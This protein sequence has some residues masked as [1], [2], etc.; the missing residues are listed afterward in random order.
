MAHV[1]FLAEKK[2]NISKYIKK[3]PNKCKK[4]KTGMSVLRIPDAHISAL[5]VRVCVYEMRHRVGMS[6]N[7]DQDTYSQKHFIGGSTDA[8]SP[9]RLLWSITFEITT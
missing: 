5:S 9:I 7:T 1:F 3:S 8:A 6:Y 4:N 2:P